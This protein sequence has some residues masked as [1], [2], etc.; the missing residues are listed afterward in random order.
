MD[1]PFGAFIRHDQV[2]RKGQPGGPLTD[3]TFGAKDLFDVADHITGGGSPD[4][5]DS[6]PPAKT[7]A[8]AVAQLLQAG[9][10]LIGK[11]Q[12]DEMAFS[13]TGENAHYGTPVNA[14]APGRIPGG[15]SSG[16]AAAV[17]GGLVDFALG[18]DTGGS[19]RI[20]ASYCGVFGLRT[21]Q[22]RIPTDGVQPLAPGFDT[23]GWFSRKAGLMQ[24]VGRVLLPDYRQ[25]VAP[26]RLLLARD[27]FGLVP[28]ETR[29]ALAPALAKLESRFES[30]AKV[31]VSDHGPD[32]WMPHFRTLQMHQVWQCHGD[33]VR[34][35]KPAFGPGVAERFAMSATITEQAAVESGE[36]RRAVAARLHELLPPDTLLCL[37]TAPGI[38][39]LRDTPEAALDAF[40]QQAMALTCIAGLSGCPQL[41]LPLAELDGCPLGVSLMAAPGGDEALLAFATG[42]LET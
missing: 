33:W 26:R 28:A 35:R 8:P 17:A 40:R 1:D 9:A 3:L 18:S 37:P 2:S 36:V 39:P 41:S 21:S 10:G 16:S 19:V 34:R 29:I 15:S 42:L 11:T 12:T 20:P 14:N 31:D 7:T 24:R 5:L 13:I 38:A 32:R 30:H 27:A 23:V 6:H 25:P 22:G 4:W